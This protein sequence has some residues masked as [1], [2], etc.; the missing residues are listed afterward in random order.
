[1][2]L[3]ALAPN[4]LEPTVKLVSQAARHGSIGRSLDSLFVGQRDHITTNG[5]VPRLF[6]ARRYSPSFLSLEFAASCRGRR[7]RNAALLGE[8]VWEVGDDV[9]LLEMGGQWWRIL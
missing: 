4:Q 6:P 7:P 2:V 3:I 8:S 5:S 9:V 1:M